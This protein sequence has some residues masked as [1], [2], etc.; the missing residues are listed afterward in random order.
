[1]VA[2][3]LSEMKELKKSQTNVSTA[4]QT[5]KLMCFLNNPEINLPVESQDDFEKIETLL[6]SEEECNASVSLSK[7]F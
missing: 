7:V 6:T 4:E 3:V 1:M 5:L 2:E